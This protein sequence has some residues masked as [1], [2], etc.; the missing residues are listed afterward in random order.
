M[1]N[2]MLV[3]VCALAA[4]PAF[5]AGETYHDPILCIK[6]KL[7]K[8]PPG[9]NENRSLV[10]KKGELPYAAPEPNSSYLA[11]ASPWTAKMWRT[12]SFDSGLGL[13]NETPITIEGLTAE[14]LSIIPV[15]EDSKT[16]NNVTYT[17][18]VYA[19]KFKVSANI[20]I[21]SDVIQGDL[22]RGGLTTMVYALCTESIKTLR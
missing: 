6:N 4:L 12:N 3:A 8:N 21:T 13:L 22:L 15:G 5:G 16:V 7:D 11:D 17:T 1:R 20:P 19:A 14:A 18:K 2:H 10:F 9:V